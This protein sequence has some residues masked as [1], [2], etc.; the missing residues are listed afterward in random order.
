MRRRALLTAGLT[1]LTATAGCFGFGFGSD[2]TRGTD[3]RLRSTTDADT[4]HAASDRLETLSPPERAAAVSARRG[5][6][7]TMWTPE[8]SSEPFSSV[9]YMADGETYLAVETPVV[10]T[11]ERPGY[12]VRLEFDAAR[13]VEASD[14]RRIAFSD[15]PA[16]DRTALFATLGYPNDREME[17]FQRAHSIRIGGTLAYPTDEAQSKSALVPEPNYD[18]VRIGGSE[19]RLQV[20]GTTTVPMA[21]RRIEL[22]T[23]AE[24]A[25]E[26]A[27]IVY[28]RD[29]I[30]LDE[31]TLSAEQRDILQ[32]AIDDDGYDECAPYSDAYAELQAMLRRDDGDDGPRRQF[33]YANYLDQW[34]SVSLSEYVA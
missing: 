27:A 23:V 9:D 32:T 5:E 33:D 29:G 18:Y 17:K 19:F 7:P 20:T 22:R 25:A 3:L 13:T 21:Q 16:V 28:E 11:V 12:E 24:S 2:C 34:Y 8:S 4:A 31:R 15:L 1:G 26:F 10:E 30:D 14:S 6:Q